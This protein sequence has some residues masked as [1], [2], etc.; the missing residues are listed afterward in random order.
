MRLETMSFSEVQQLIEIYFS[1]TGDRGTERAVN[2]MNI[3]VD[4]FSRT[5]IEKE[6]GTRSSQMST[7][8]QPLSQSFS[9]GITCSSFRGPST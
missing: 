4:E 9:L 7:L 5:G 6:R 2:T 3:L 1:N 8:S